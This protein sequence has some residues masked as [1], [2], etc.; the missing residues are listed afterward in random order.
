MQEVNRILEKYSTSVIQ[1]LNKENM[2][3]IIEFLKKEKCDYIDELL[4]DYLDLFT[5]E[6][7]EFMSRYEILNKKFEGLFLKIASEDMNLLEKF[8]ENQ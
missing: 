8:F 4:E 1:N 5:I 7:K 6:Y 3:N 2:Y